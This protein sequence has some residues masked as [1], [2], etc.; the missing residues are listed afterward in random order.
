MPS[1][2][3][4]AGEVHLHEA[5]QVAGAHGEHRAG[6]FVRARERPHGRGGL[7]AVF[8]GSDVA[9]GRAV[10]DRLVRARRD[11]G[12][13]EGG[14]EVVDE[15]LLPVLLA[16]HLDEAAEDAEADVVVGEELA[17]GEQ[18]RQRGDHAD[19]LLDGVLAATGVGEDIALEAAL[20]AEEL[21][22][23]DARGGDLVG[24]GELGQVGADRKVQ[25]EQ[26]VVDELHDERRRPDLRDGTDLEDG[27]GRRLDLGGGAEQAA[28]GVDDLAVLEDGDDGA[29]HL[30][31]GDQLGELGVQE[32]VDLGE[33]L[34]PITIRRRC[35]RTFVRSDRPVRFRWSDPTTAA[36]I[37]AGPDRGL[38]ESVMN[39]R[40][41]ERARRNVRPGS[42]GALRRRP[43]RQRPSALKMS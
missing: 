21:A 25:V 13:A 39:P 8:A 1:A 24:E 15:R 7:D 41:R 3:G 38:P 2:A 28:G 26:A 33:A 9:D 5:E 32:L 6:G 4:A 18:L 17:R 20:V 34:H 23:R 22:G 35:R 19:V 16:E 37:R 31:L 10:E 30:V 36:P 12:E 27:V 43:L 14:H 42:G 29:G 40:S 11:M